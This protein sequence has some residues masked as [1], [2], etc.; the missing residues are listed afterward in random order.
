MASCLEGLSYPTRAELIDNDCECSA[1][2]QPLEE[3]C[4]RL[5][6]ADT[7]EKLPFQL[8]SR[9]IRPI[10]MALEIFCLKANGDFFNSICQQQTLMQWRFMFTEVCINGGRADLAAVCCGG[11]NDRF[12]RF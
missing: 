4:K 3:T 8:W 1:S 7:V 12:H 10:E 11:S 5:L 6:L 9:N 2:T